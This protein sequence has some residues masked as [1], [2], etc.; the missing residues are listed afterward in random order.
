MRV[1]VCVYV[2][3]C[4]YVCVFANTYAKIACVEWACV[5]VWV[6]G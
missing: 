5:C 2:C 6:G 4:V 3:M 1:Y